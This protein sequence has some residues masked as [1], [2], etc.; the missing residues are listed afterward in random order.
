MTILIRIKSLGQTLSDTSLHA[1]MASFK[2]PAAY[3]GLSCGKSDHSAI[4]RHQARPQK[5]NKSIGSCEAIG[6]SG[7][8]GETPR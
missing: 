8:Y 7:L 1:L 2:T 6:C 4:A 3:A 5:Q